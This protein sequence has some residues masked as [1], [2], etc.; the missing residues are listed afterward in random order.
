MSYNILKILKVNATVS[1]LKLFSAGVCVKESCFLYP[2][3]RLGHRLS[4]QKIL[5]R[6]QLLGKMFYKMILL[7]LSTNI[8]VLLLLF[9]EKYEKRYPQL[10]YLHFPLPQVLCPLTAVNCSLKRSSMNGQWKAN[11]RGIWEKNNNYTRVA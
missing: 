4:R 8:L 9:E 6:R 1:I 3:G 5:L 2:T 11:I 7:V 10:Y